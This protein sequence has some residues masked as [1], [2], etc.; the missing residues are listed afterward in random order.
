MIT[1]S[2]R[3]LTVSTVVYCCHVN[4]SVTSATSIISYISSPVSLTSDFNDILCTVPDSISSTNQKTLNELNLRFSL[5]QKRKPVHFA[6]SK[7]ITKLK[8]LNNNIISNKK[9]SSK[10]FKDV[11]VVA[12]KVYL[13]LN[14]NKSNPGFCF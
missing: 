2:L 5:K 11:F 7:G 8:D 6:C 3:K 10:M 14:I 9:G 12:K 4:V 13:T 1:A